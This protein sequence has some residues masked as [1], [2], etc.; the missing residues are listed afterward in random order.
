[1]RYSEHMNTDAR[2]TALR[3]YRAAG[4]D[5]NADLAALSTNP[6]GVVVWLPHL[7]VLMKPADSRRPAEWGDLGDNPTGADGW[8]VHLLTGELALARRLLGL[9][10]RRSWA[11]F[12]RGRRSPVPHRL[13]WQRLSRRGTT[14][15]PTPQH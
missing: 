6:Q 4:R 11:C 5:L 8:Y 13:S 3:Y 15:T 9:V 10:P 1:M 14:A 12:Q 2:L 7:V